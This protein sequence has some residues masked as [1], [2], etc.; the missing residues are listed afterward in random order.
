[1]NIWNQGQFSA[2][3]LVNNTIILL[4]QFTFG[5]TDF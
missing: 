1:M 2:M 4:K 5:L 3:F